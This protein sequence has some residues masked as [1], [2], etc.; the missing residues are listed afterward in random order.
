MLW[1]SGGGILERASVED[2]RG[3]M[4]GR[5]VGRSGGGGSILVGRGNVG[6]GSILKGRSAGRSAGRSNARSG[7]GVPDP[8]SNLAAMEA[9]LEGRMVC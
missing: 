5:G 4:A 3:A 2:A 8:A 9:V 1:R 7:G 6:R